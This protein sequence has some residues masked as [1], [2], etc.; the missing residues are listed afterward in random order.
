M[1][2]A[3]DVRQRLKRAGATWVK[4]KTRLK[5][6]RL[7]KKIQA[8]VV[9]A[10]VE[11]TLLFDAQTRTWQVKEL[12]KIQSC[13]DKMYRHVWSRK[14]KPPLRQMEEEGKNMQDLRNEMGLKSVRLKVEKRCLERIGHVMRMEDD[15]MVKAAV[16]GWME[17][18][19]G[20][21]KRKGKKR[22][23]VLFWKK[24]VREAGLDKTKIGQMT[25][26]RKE[27]KMTVKERINHLDKWERRGGK[28]SQEER[29]DRNQTSQV[30]EEFK[31]EDCQ[32]ICKSK[33]GLVSHS[34]TKHNISSQKVTFKCNLCSQIFQFKSNLT[35]HQTIC[36]GLL[37]EDPDMKRCEKCMKL[38]TR[39]NFARHMKNC[40]RGREEREAAPPRELKGERAVCGLCNSNQSK[41]NM[42]RH[43]DSQACQIRREANL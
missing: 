18:L 11:S 8:R 29:G 15:R 34:R 27:W 39:S 13:V 41:T 31:C 17:D 28:R 43:Q 19:E 35:T 6:S 38:V 24:L 22:K 37:N 10:T 33:A 14:T 4:V 2:P 25:S 36:V 16:L 21:T 30:E 40:G 7:S 1:G 42:S 3:E 9:E 12:K 26:N 32:K 23:T 20:V 5:G